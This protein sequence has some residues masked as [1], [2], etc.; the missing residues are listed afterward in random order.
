M[1]GLLLYHGLRRV[2]DQA[3]SLETEP[4]MTESYFP[5]FSFCTIWMG[6]PAQ[7]FGGIQ[8][9]LHGVPFCVLG[10]EVWGY[11]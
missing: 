10:D 9:I 5:K 6:L 1:W 7:K 2:C 4:M 3:S 8:S 11:Y